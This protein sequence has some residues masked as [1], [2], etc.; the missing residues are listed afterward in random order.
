[1]AEIAIPFHIALEAGLLFEIAPGS[2]STLRDHA[3]ANDRAA[4]HQPATPHPISQGAILRAQ[5]R[6][7]YFTDE[8]WLHP[9][10]RSAGIDY[11]KLLVLIAVVAVPWAAISYVVW[12]VDSR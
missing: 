8:A 6:L 9:T 11:L 3:P 7:T 12:L 5:A 10:H 4:R 2:T 1:M